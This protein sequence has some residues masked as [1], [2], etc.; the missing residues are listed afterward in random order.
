MSRH[1]ARRS[2]DYRKWE[3]RQ[4]FG[5]AH[6]VAAR[7]AHERYILPDGYI[8]LHSGTPRRRPRISDKR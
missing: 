8:E 5:D 4:K 6:Q 2:A 1:F 3:K 7:A